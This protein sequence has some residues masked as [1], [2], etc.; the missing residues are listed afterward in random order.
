MHL[1]TYKDVVV[2]VY[3]SAQL[4]VQH[5]QHQLLNV[6]DSN[7]FLYH[8]HGCIVWVSLMPELFPCKLDEFT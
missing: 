5:E 3:P 6:E 2:I 4:P 7:G 8:L 1:D